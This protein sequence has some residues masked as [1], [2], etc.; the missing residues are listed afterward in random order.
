MTPE[1]RLEEMGHKL[2]PAPAPVGSY[3]PFVRTGDLILTSGQ[4]PMREGKL[5]FA[6]SAGAG[7]FA[8][9]FSA[10]GSI[11]PCCLRFSVMPTWA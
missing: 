2:P 8:T 4:L 6:G 5:T 11:T 7:G 1:E 9:S 10:A 3:V